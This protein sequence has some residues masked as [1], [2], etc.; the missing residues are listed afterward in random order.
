[1]ISKTN[2]LANLNKA[3]TVFLSG[4]CLGE[5]TNAD[6]SVSGKGVVSRPSSNHIDLLVST[7]ISPS[8]IVGR[9]I[10]SDNYFDWNVSATKSDL[11]V[12]S[13]NVL[14]VSPGITQITIEHANA[15]STNLNKRFLTIIR[16]N[17]QA[18]DQI[19]ACLT[20]GTSLTSTNVTIRHNGTTTRE[21]IVNLLIVK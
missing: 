9:Y 16:G 15:G 11:I 4:E 2:G 20:S 5:L 21:V 12:T 19:D 17:E 8:V 18:N 6:W 7:G 14:T 3:V 10:I 13:S 1:M